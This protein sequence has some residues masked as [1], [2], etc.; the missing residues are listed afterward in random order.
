M[1]TIQQLINDEEEAIVAYEEFLS[2]SKHSVKTMALVHKII[3]QEKGHIR[4]LK[5]GR[6]K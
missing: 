3:E 1:I 6:V 4:I 2:Q 5:S